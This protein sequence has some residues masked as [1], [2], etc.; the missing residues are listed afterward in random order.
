MWPATSTSSA[1]VAV[2]T[3]AAGTDTTAPS[4][5]TNLAATAQSAT[6][7]TLA[8]DASTDETGGSGVAGYDV[9]RNGAKVG[10]S[11]TT[12]FTDTG[13]SAGTTYSYTVKAKDVAGN[14]SAA[15][16]ALPVATSQGCT[17]GGTVGAG[18]W[19]TSGNQILDANNPVRI[20]G[21]NWYGFETTDS[22]P[23]GLYSVD[24]KS[25][26]DHIKALGYNTIRFPYSD[27]MIAQTA[28]PSSINYSN[29]Q[30]ADLAGLS[31]LQILD[32]IVAYS[33]TQGLKII[34]DHHRSEAG[35]SAEDNGLW[36]TG[37]TPSRCSWPTG[38]SW[39]PATTTT[40]PSSATT[41]TTSPTPAPTASMPTARP[42]ALAPPPTVA[43]PPNARATPSR[44]STRRPLSWS[45]ASASTPT[46]PASS[47]APGGAG[48]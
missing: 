39:P 17:S 38:G 15:S 47:W 25:I 21:I 5:P 9:Y 6:S 45:R 20:A 10:S 23:H 16:T 8:W 43:L 33:G 18:F 34:L 3:S 24:Y 30:N 22:V 27:Q 7:V 44:P 26:L 31:P 46:P 19:H 48:T 35:N 41:C 42:G 29:G 37:S 32:K 36:F 40:P 2:T 13:L 11:T 1:A 4:V 12:G 28:P 14:I